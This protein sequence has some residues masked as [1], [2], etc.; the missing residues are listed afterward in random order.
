GMPESERHWL[1][2]AVEPGF[3]Y[4]GK[5]KSFEPDVDAAA[6][7]ARMYAYGNEL[8]AEKRR[9][10]ADDMLSI[11]VH[12]TLE[13]VDPPR[14]TDEELYMF[15]SLLFSAGAETTRNAIAGGVAALV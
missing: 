6:A 10:P 15:F 7:R 13:G 11:V 2:E 5:R 9:N 12:A 1:F 8:I 4:K 3:D 14:L